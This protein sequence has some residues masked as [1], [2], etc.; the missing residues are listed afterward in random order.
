MRRL[1]PMLSLL[2]ALCAAAPA[3][4]QS[5]AFKQVLQQTHALM[6]TGNYAE[7]EIWAKKAIDLAK[8]ESGADSSD[9]AI[10]LNNLAELYRA[11]GRYAEAETLYKSAITIDQKARGPDNPSVATDINN[12][13]DLYDAQGRYA[14]SLPLQQRALAIRENASGPDSSDVALSLNDLAQFYYHQGRY[15]EAERAY[16][17]ALAIREKVLGPDN[18]DVGVTLTGL[19]IVYRAQGRFAEA[20]PLLN[21]ALAIHE[22]AFGPDHPFFATSLDDLAE[23]YRAQGRYADAEPLQKRALAIR[24]K[25]LGPDNLDVAESLNNLAALYQDQGRYV[26][27]LP[28]DQRTLAIFQKVY[29]PEHS[30]VAVSFANLAA[31]YAALGRYADAEP[32]NKRALAIDANA[33]GPDS[34]AVARDLDNLATIYR[35]QRRDT[36]AEPA[37]KRALAIRVNTLG[38]Y[39]PDVA[40][41]LNNLALLYGAQGRYADA[42]P[43]INR[44]A[45]IAASRNAGAKADNK[46]GEAELR[47]QRDIFLNDVAVTGR[48]SAAGTSYAPRLREEAFAAM[49]WSKASG[50]AAAVAHMAARF[51][52]GSDALAALVRQ[53][54]DT[55]NRLDADEAAILKSVTQPPDK[56]DPKAEA[57]RRANADGIRQ[58]LTQLDADLA[59]K[60]PA[61]AE[62]ASPTPISIAE[63][64]NLLVPNQA[65]IVYAVGT[66]ESY[67]AVV[68]HNSAGIF[69]VPIGAQALSAAVKKLRDSLDPEGK[70]SVP[71][72]EA[73]MAFQ[74]YQQFF[75]PAEPA[76][77]GVT[78]LYVV[79]DGALE[80]LPLG[81][82]LT[83]KPAADTLSVPGQLR[84]APWL[85]RRYPVS[86]LPS[87]S[88]LKVLRQFASAAHAPQPYMGFGDPVLKPQPGG[89]RGA[90]PLAR[91]VQSV[92]RGDAV[93][94]AELRDL[95]SLPETAGELQAEAKLFQAAPDSVLLQ[96][97]ATV[98]AVKQADLVSRRVIAFAT[99]GLLA[100]DVGVAEPGLVLTPPANPT[101]QDDG[102][103]KAS[104][105]AQL[106]LNA[107]LVIL[108]ACNTAA[109][110]GTP[111][112]EGFSGLSKAF[113]YAGARSLMVS[114]WSVI[115]DSTVTLM[116]RMA[117]QLK[118]KGVGRAEALRCA[119]IDLMDDKNH[120]EFAH[121]MFWAP[122][123]VVGE[124]GA[125]K[126]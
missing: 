104:E 35:L 109:S 62:L 98:T 90:P 85:A 38:P 27:A 49:Q 12:L 103:L 65:L 52:A 82:L 110:D 88:S 43:F 67:I 50:T 77:K 36:D 4:A 10:S 26:E 96:E 122:F 47:A 99:H 118:Q 53:R 58:R 14:E 13:A 81:V 83:G 42:Y 63:T 25:A 126:E 2:V 57:A 72:F 111:G 94:Q 121:P 31:L 108:S 29:G 56:R 114:H 19:G 113:L 24:E 74:L 9:Y 79:T 86:V 17:R 28:L 69:G 8:N 45:V 84:A 22:K 106:K 78:Q 68:N 76:L 100:G 48:L 112:A 37:Y 32:L 70:T 97:A 30:Y 6:V 41:S 66:N 54:Q 102:L 95:P 107:D 44:A 11:Q 51:A 59:A 21:R 34:P 80:S 125:V 40:Q 46:G 18:S 15:A 23:L 93:D 105:I 33:Q 20:A 101:P 87:V 124:G 92:Y 61:Y 123:V 55:H 1:L 71:P 120:P 39:H 91:G 7:A 89:D 119:E 64:Q 16:K 5:D 73:S 75:A 115:S 117:A 116:T 3:Y 60:F